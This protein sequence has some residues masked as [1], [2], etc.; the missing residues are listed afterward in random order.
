MFRL[1][2]G[3]RSEVRLHFSG[4]SCILRSNQVLHKLKNAC[5]TI[6]RA[7]ARPLAQASTVPYCSVYLLTTPYLPPDN[8]RMH[9]YGGLLAWHLVEN[10]GATRAIVYWGS[11]DYYERSRARFESAIGARQPSPEWA[12]AI[13]DFHADKP[14]WWPVSAKEGLIAV[15][16]VI[17]AVTVIWN[18]GKSVSEPLWTAPHVEVS[19]VGANV[20]VNEGDAVSVTT[21]ARNDTQFIPV[22]LTASAELDRDGKQ[23]EPID[24]TPTGPQWVTAGTPETL[25]GS[26][27]AP[28]L[29]SKHPPLREFTLKLTAVARTWRFGRP[30]DAQPK[31]IPF[32]VW[33]RSFGWSSELTHVQQ[34]SPNIDGLSGV[35]YTA[36]AYSTGLE[37]TVE[38]ETPA[39][40]KITVTILSPFAASGDQ[41]ESTIGRMKTVELPFVTGSLDNHHPYSFQI[42]L[43]AS[44]SLPGGWDAIEKSVK[45]FFN[46]RS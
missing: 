46:L 15:A 8:F 1:S 10:A 25:T 11:R 2:P 26:L 16:A 17:G 37:G 21:N 23:V 39:S 36:Q 19:F 3:Q 32:D 30:A 14:A 44:N 43:N 45:V 12:G 27:K 28:S 22:Q 38:L 42:D 29:D 34:K 41:L 6:R 31:T 7:L 4:Y 40:N 33:P 18:T 9:S 5:S 24:L 35:L 13:G 20:D